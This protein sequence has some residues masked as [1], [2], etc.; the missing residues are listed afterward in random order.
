MGSEWPDVELETFCTKIGSGATPRGGSKVYLDVGEIALIRSQNIYNDRFAHDGLTYITSE[1]AEQLANVTIEEGDILLNITGDSVARCCQVDRNILPARV[2]QHVAIIRTKPDELDPRFVRYFLISP[3]QQA[4]MLSM[5]H[6]GATRKALTKSMIESFKVPKPDLEIQRTIAHILGTLDDKIELNREMNRTLEQMAQAIFQSWFIDFDPVV[7]NAVQ[8]GNP[9]PDRFTETATRYRENPDALGLPQEV[10][11]LFPDRFVESEL[12]EIPVGWEVKQIGDAVRCVGGATPSTKKPEFWEGGTHPF[13]TPK[14]M[15]SLSAP[16]IL[17]TDRHIT[18]AGIE[19]ISSRIIPAGTVLL[20]SRA[21][22]GYLAIN[23]VPISV[24]QGLIAMICEG[25]LSNH[26]VLHWTRE[27][28][29][30]IKSKAG[31]TTFAEISKKNFRPILVL[32]PSSRILEQFE[33]IVKPLH[34]AV[35]E[36]VI[37]SQTLAK[38]RDT[39]LPKL[40]SG[41]LSVPDAQFQVEELV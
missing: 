9:I 39:L 14:D 18:E 36:N 29:E 3:K 8:S 10:L 24:N 41:E 38:L 22:I 13:L 32:E 7:R 28:M 25:V 31:G 2:N 34:K 12:G 6:A 11:D 30:V 26:Y 23:E 17:D 40:I 21:P 1:H 27:N 20:S 5:S 4:L 33:K 37:S 19:K 35:V 16:V 15:S